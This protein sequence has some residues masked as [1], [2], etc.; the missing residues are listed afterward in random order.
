MPIKNLTSDEFRNLIYEGKN[1][2]KESYSKDLEQIQNFSYNDF[3]CY[4]SKKYYDSLIFI[5]SYDE[6][7][8]YGILKFAYFES[9]KNYSISYCS[10]NKLFLNK[11]ICYKM[12][13]SFTSYFSYKYPKEILCISQYSVSGWKYLRPLLLTLCRQQKITFKDNIVGYMEYGREYLEEFNK[14]RKISIE[15]N[16]EMLY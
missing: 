6:V 3:G 4:G 7:H 10:T 1:L 2:P 5:V 14:L 12:V 9:S 11:G 15:I 13:N 16:G 8:I